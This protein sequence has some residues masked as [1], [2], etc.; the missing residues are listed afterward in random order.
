[1]LSPKKKKQDLLFVSYTAYILALLDSYTAYTSDGLHAK[2][3]HGLPALFLTA[4]LL[5]SP[6]SINS[7]SLKYIG[8][9]ELLT[10][11]KN[12]MLR[13]RREY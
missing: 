3:Q 4:A 7:C 9:F 1:M 8:I 10:E 13:T 2:L 11:K 6:T 5:R 12:H